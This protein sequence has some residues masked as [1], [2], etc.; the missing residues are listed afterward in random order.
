MAAQFI[1]GSGIPRLV[2]ASVFLELSMRLAFY[3][4]PG[5]EV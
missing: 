3:P 1:D 4:V 5:T 2:P